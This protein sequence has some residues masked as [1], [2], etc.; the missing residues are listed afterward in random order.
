MQKQKEL[1]LYN[2]SRHVVKSNCGSSFSGTGLFYTYPTVLLLKQ[3][4]DNNSVNG[5]QMIYTEILCCS[6]PHFKAY[7]IIA[8]KILYRELIFWIFPRFT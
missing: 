4:C 6:K 2:I 8:N 5:I 7:T 3:S 1:T